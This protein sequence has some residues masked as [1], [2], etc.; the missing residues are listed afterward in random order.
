MRRFRDAAGG[1]L[2]AYAEVTRFGLARLIDE[3][4]ALAY[5]VIQAVAS[6]A[7]EAVLLPARASVN[8]GGAEGT[9]PSARSGRVAS[10]RRLEQRMW[11]GLPGA[12]R[13]GGPSGAALGEA[14]CPRRPDGF[15]GQGCRP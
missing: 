7:V 11:I 14:G 13:I 1:L 10:R 3:Y 4:A 8:P 2:S 9:R 15:K 6:V 5:G 12:G